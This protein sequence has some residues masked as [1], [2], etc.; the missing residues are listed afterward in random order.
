MYSNVSSYVEQQHNEKH[1]IL[2][3]FVL[4][5]DVD[6]GELLGQASVIHNPVKGERQQK[7]GARNRCDFS[8]TPLTRFSEIITPLGSRQ[9]L[10]LNMAVFV[11]S[12][13]CI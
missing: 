1:K 7:V 10:W 13:I 2:S 4:E 5:Y 8:Q 9:Q 11:Q 3:I 6:N 12:K